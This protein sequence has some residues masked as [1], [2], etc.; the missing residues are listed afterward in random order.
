MTEE[1]NKHALIGIRGAVSED[2]PF[3]FST[4][5][6][7]LKHGNEWFDLIDKEA[8]FKHYHKIIEQILAHPRTQVKIV[9][10][11]DD[12]E[13][14][15]GYS[16]STEYQYHWVFVKKSWRG[17]GIGRD[18]M[19]SPATV[20]THLTKVGVSLLKKNPGVKFN[21]FL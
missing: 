15:L 5:L 2:V 10:L 1:I 4:W 20:V 19:K 6:K 8:Y 18:L 21:P 16:V 14:I 13:V 17:I 3:I 12:P 7:G 9:C 11:K